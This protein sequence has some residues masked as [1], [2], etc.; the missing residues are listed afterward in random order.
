L[1]R[2]QKGFQLPVKTTVLLFFILLGAPFLFSFVSQGLPSLSWL[3][4]NFQTIKLL[5]AENIL[6]SILAFL[7]LRFLFS[8]ISIPGSGV[9]TVAGG[10]IFGVWLGSFLSLMAVG[11]GLLVTF[12]ISRY[13]VQDLV[14]RKTRKYMELIDK[15]IDKYG[16]GFLLMLRL[17]EVAPS[18]LINTAFALTTMKAWTYCWVSLVGILPGVIIFANAGTRLAELE[19][20]AGLMDPVAAVSLAAL[21]L[22]LLSSKKALNHLKKRLADKG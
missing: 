22:L 10:A 19:S 2:K 14:R 15:G 17:I 11:A 8:V 20:L 7:G 5:S 3:Q 1:P 13:A 6:F 21:G 9:L 16:A 4:D 12:L 18:F